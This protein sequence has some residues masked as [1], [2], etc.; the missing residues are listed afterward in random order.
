MSIR[1]GIG[2]W[3]G[4]PL[5]TMTATRRKHLAHCALGDAA[6]PVCPFQAAGTVCNKK[7][8]VCSLQAYDTAMGRRPA[9]GTINPHLA[10]VNQALGLLPAGHEAARDKQA[11]KTLTSGHRIWPDMVEYH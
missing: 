7:G 9:D 2:E 5:P 3:Y 4:E 11:V 8:G 10:G 6:A 1:F